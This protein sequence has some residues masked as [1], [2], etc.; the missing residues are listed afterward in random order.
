MAVIK[1]GLLKVDPGLFLWTCITFGVLLL[2]LWKTAWR[3]IVDALDA[4]A[5]KIRGDI[6]NAE[7]ARD[8][9]AKVLAQHTDAMKKAKDEAS[10]I[11]AKSREEAERIKNEIVEKANTE[12]GT[13]VERARK[14]VDMAKESALAEIKTEVVFLSTEIASKII[15]KNINPDDQKALVE[16]ALNK[17]RTVQ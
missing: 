6:E 2:L 9:A 13:I 15:S 1:E 8:E 11:L 3:P 14:E 7:K 10:E 5:E 16:E 4:R 12:A 17:M